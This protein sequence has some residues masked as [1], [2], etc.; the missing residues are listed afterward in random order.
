MK[1]YYTIGEFAEL[2]SVSSVTIWRA[3]VRGEIPA[4]RPC[5]SYRIPAEAE[6]IFRRKK[7]V[8]A[9]TPTFVPV[10]GDVLET[11]RRQIRKGVRAS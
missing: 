11:A 2:F 6:E 8:V 3:V 5:R 9:V 7:R 10:S 1:R 4:I